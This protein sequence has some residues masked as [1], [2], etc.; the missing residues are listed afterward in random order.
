[1]NTRWLS[2]EIIHQLDTQTR[3]KNVDILTEKSTIV[4]DWNYEENSKFD[5][6]DGQMIVKNIFT[7]YNT[8]IEPRLSDNRTVIELLPR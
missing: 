8:K 7:R 3:L 6:Y 2:E 4:I 1:M 5:I